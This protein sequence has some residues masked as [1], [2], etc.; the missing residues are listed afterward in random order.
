MS[1]SLPRKDR[2]THIFSMVLL[3]IT[4]NMEGNKCF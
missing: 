3:Y 1:S 4:H 2:K